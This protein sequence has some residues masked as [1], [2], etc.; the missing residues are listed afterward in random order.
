MFERMKIN[1]PCFTKDSSPVP[2]NFTTGFKWIKNISIEIIQ[3]YFPSYRK[4]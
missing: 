2:K 1:L 3:P 4:K